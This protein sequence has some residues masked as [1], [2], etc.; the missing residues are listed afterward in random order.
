MDGQT[1]TRGLATVNVLSACQVL[2][3]TAVDWCLSGQL[4]EVDAA[5]RADSQTRL[6]L[7]MIIVK[8]VDALRQLHQLPKRLINTTNGQNIQ[9]SNSVL[10]N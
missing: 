2:R 7:V 6:Q 1:S 9:H 3:S 4:Q 8:A 10:S 5:R